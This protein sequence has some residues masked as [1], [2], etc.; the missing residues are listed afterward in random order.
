MG[1]DK[2]KRLPED[3]KSLELLA[4]K[5]NERAQSELGRRLFRKDLKKEAAKWLH[6]AAEQG[7]IRA[8][9]GLELFFIWSRQWGA[10]KHGGIGEVVSKSY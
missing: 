3:I 4:E 2:G 9:S 6:K 5:G 10:F 7:D 1:A 8:Q